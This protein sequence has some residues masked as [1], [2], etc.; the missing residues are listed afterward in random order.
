MKT[1]IFPVKIIVWARRRIPFCLQIFLEQGSQ[2]NE[3]TEK[4]FL[5]RYMYF[6]QGWLPHVSFVFFPG[7]T[8]Q[9]RLDFGKKIEE[10][11]AGMSFPGF[12]LFIGN[13]NGKLSAE[14]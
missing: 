9:H 5:S 4:G 6:S 11:M 3:N 7:K 1:R 13:A 14:C 12:S 10:R 2:E 8:K